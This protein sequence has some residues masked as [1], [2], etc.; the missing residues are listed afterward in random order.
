MEDPV[1]NPFRITIV[2]LLLLG[3]TSQARAEL[4]SGTCALVMDQNNAPSADPRLDHLVLDGV[5]VNVLLPPSYHASHRRYPVLYLFHGAFG[6]EDSWST[7]TDVLAFTAGLP[8]GE[9]AIVVMPDGGH[10][11]AGRD[12]ADGTHPQESFVI[13]SLLP[14]I[15]SH[16]RTQADRSHRAAA[17]FSAGGMNAMVFA[18]RHPDLFIAAGSF[19]GFVDPFDPAGIQ[20][21]EQFA[22]LDNEL[23]GATDDA[24]GLWGDP[25]LHPMG[26]E[27]HDPRNLASNLDGISLYLSSGTGTPCA[28]DPDDPAL[29]FAEATVFA[30]TRHLDAALTAAGIR[31]ITELR[32]CGLHLYSNAGA[33]LRRFWPEML[34]ASGRPAPQDFDHR[35]GDASAMVWGWQFTADP[36]R[37]PEFLDVIGASRHGLAITGSG[38]QSITTAPLFARHQGV[39]IAGA[40]TAPQVVRADDAGRLA[41]TVDLGPAHTLEEDTPAAQAALAADPH[42]FVT[43]TVRFEPVGR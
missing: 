13:G 1:S 41:F 8:A 16:Y 36:A 40:G 15:D 34:R 3:A 2:W 23:C 32:P 5:H 27:G 29:E 19:S 26:W 30:M 43:R 37:A 10:L 12:W 20:V 42:Y 4:A 21:V 17:G 24:F 25:E 38:I 39:R 14:F 35:T 22:Q 7:Q 18:A 6:D 9:Q 33:D 11:P 31:H 28:G